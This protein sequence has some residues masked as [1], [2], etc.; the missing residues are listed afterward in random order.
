MCDCIEQARIKFLE[1][2]TA[3]A[4]EKGWDIKEFPAPD[5]EG[6]TFFFEKKL[7]EEFTPIQFTTSF[8]YTYDFLKKD[9][10]RSRPMKASV[11]VGF[12]YCPFCGEPYKM[13]LQPKVVQ[14]QHAFEIDLEYILGLP[15]DTIFST[16]IIRDL[17]LDKDN[18]KWIAVKGGGDDWALY[19]AP[20]KTAISDM[21]KSSIKVTTES[22]I[23]RLVGCTDKALTK[24][25]F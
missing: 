10:T 25:R 17:R 6:I 1:R 4:N 8:N 20:A 24:Y 3:Q 22:I 2:A 5:F 13:E 23:K 9:K 21:L 14:P 7:D 15:A 19:Y 16:G 11:M 12:S 18:I